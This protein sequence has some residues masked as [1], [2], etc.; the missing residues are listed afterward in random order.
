[1]LNSGTLGA[2]LPARIWV[3][4]ARSVGEWT[5]R[6]PRPQP[7]YEQPSPTLLSCP[8]TQKCSPL[9]A[10]DSNGDA[11][12]PHRD[13]NELVKHYANRLK[14]LIPQEQERASR[15]GRRHSRS[16]PRDAGK[17]KIAVT[18]SAAAR[19][20][21]ALTSEGLLDRLPAFPDTP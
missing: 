1:M 13:T 9:N 14:R 7:N 18:E 12:P 17:G 19:M 4:S 20:K 6:S 11:A 8:G 15:A 10:Q 21:R 2:S 5:R 16:R 3:N